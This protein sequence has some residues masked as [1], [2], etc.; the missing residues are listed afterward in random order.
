[1]TVAVGQIPK[2]SLLDSFRNILNFYYGN[3]ALQTIDNLSQDSLKE[4]NISDI[5]NISKELHLN[6]SYNRVDPKIIEAHLLPCIAIDADDRAI[7]IVAFEDHFVCIKKGLD[8]SE[9]LITKDEFDARYERFVFFSKKHKRTNTLDIGEQKSKNW[10]YTPI[11]KAWKSYVEIGLLTIFINI[12]GLALPLFTMNVYNRVVPNFATETLFVLAFGVGVVLLFDVILKSTRVHILQKVTKK[13]A[14]ELEEELFKKTL[15]IK[16]EHDRFLVGTKTNFFRELLVVKDFF[17]SKTTH[18]LDLPFF[19]T[20]V[21]VIYLINPTIAIVPIVTAIVLLGLNFLMQYPI[22]KLHKES[23]KEAQSK[24][25]YLVEQLQGIE[26]IKLSNALPKRVFM[27][28]KITNFYNHLQSKIQFLNAFSSFASQGL[29]QSVSLATIIVGVYCIHEGTL[30]VGGLIAV[31]ILASRAMVPVINLS[32]VL[33]QYK[34]VK[35]ALESLNEYWHLPT[36]SQKYSEFGVGQAQGKIEF[37]NVTFSYQNAKYPSLQ[38]ISFTIKPGERVGIIG[39]TGAGKSTIQKLLTSIQ[40]PSSG[41]VFLDDM[42]ISTI[43]PVELRQN[44]ALMPQEP[45]LFSGTLKENLELNKNISKQ[46]MNDILKKTGLY[47][48]VKKSGSSDTLDV[49]ERGQNLSVGQRHLVALARALVSESPVLILDEPT[50]GL[51]VG[52]EKNLVSHLKESLSDKTVIVITHR[53]AALEFVDR[54]ILIHDGK[55][56]ADGEK[57]RVLSMLEGKKGSL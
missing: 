50:T 18:I 45:Y 41:K 31:T 36:E 10:F 12:F 15:S 52:L 37:D 24:H 48:L 25:G 7:V 49:G 21:F 35:E 2:R 42:D 13:I 40:S 56:V 54:V 11:K 53:F 8:V 57:N 43:H 51:D 19:V 20:A 38:N 44:I 6:C 17:V 32:S 46:Q 22:S 27:W 14:N 26:A 5:K 34:Q 47:E 4:F 29:L 39:Q 23:F 55:V 9:E 28:K 3:V 1:M 30:S 16:S 33:V